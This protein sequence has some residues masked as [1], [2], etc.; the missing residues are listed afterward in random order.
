MGAPLYLQPRAYMQRP[1]AEAVVRASQR[2]HT[3]GYGTAHPSCLVRHRN[4]LR[5]RY[6]FPS[7]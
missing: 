4:V 6:P 1:A 3:L 2:L 7:L 5:V